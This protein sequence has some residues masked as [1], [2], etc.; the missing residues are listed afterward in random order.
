MNDAEFR[1]VGNSDPPTWIRREPHMFSAESLRRR[2]GGEVVA[3]GVERIGRYDFERTMPGHLFHEECGFRWD[4]HD[5]SILG[6]PLPFGCPR[7]ET[8]AQEAW[9][10]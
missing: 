2:L 7:D 8:E 4:L 5:A 1:Q 6:R 9:G 3:A 10:R